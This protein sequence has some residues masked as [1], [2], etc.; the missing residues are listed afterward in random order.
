MNWETITA[1]LDQGWVNFLIGIIGIILGIIVTYHFRHRKAM[2]YQYW[3]TYLIG[4]DSSVLPNSVKISFNDVL[5]P[6]LSW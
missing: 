5:V 1:Y 4:G 6:R 2:A 3:L